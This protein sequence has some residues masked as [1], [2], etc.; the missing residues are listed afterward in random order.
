M[1]KETC[2]FCGKK[3]KLTMNTLTYKCKYCSEENECKGIVLDR[4]D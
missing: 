2:K 1:K 3:N 4:L